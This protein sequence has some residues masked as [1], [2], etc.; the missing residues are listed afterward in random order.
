MKSI[1]RLM[2]VLAVVML[3]MLTTVAN[4]RCGKMGD[5]GNINNNNSGDGDDTPPK[6]DIT[7]T[8]LVAGKAKLGAKTDGNDTILINA[9]GF[10]D[11]LTRTSAAIAD[12]D[13]LVEMVNNPV[14]A[15]TD[16]LF[17][18][19]ITGGI[20]GNATAGLVL[21]N[22]GDL[23]NFTNF[24]VPAP[25][26]T[27]TYES[28]P[29]RT[30]SANPKN[31]A[32]VYNPAGMKIYGVFVDAQTPPASADAS[33][34]PFS[35]TGYDHPSSG[36]GHTQLLISCRSVVSTI[37][38]TTP[39]PDTVLTGGQTATCFAGV[40]S[41]AV[42]GE[43]NWNNEFNK[44][45]TAGTAFKKAFYIAVAG[46]RTDGKKLSEVLKNFPQTTDQRKVEEF[47]NEIAASEMKLLVANNIIAYK[48]ILL[49]L[50]PSTGF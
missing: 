3:A 38:T 26:G 17:D 49:K 43:G 6:P 28:G 11:I 1:S 47:M 37:T 21:V 10:G 22:T 40:R 35:F 19:T 12:S 41:T 7:I 15:T 13:G 39:N 20:A 23:G 32:A 5:G 25:G 18:L 31:N 29:Y 46:I 4:C 50:A 16:K 33:A 48:K 2:I 36:I 27:V 45:T 14:D 42:F 44:A 9:G 24:S 34:T 8:N 30:V